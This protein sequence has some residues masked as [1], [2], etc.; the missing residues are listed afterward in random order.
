MV[1]FPI[2][3]RDDAIETLSVGEAVYGK[4]AYFTT[5]T[6]HYYIPTTQHLT[7]SH[8]IL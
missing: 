7:H 1:P 3:K 2:S 4:C 5:T 8:N 6:N